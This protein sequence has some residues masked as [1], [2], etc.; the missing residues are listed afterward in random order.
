MYKSMN[1]KGSSET[2][3][4]ALRAVS[5][6]TNWS[7]IHDSVRNQECLGDEE[8]PGRNPKPSPM[9]HGYHGCQ[10]QTPTCCSAWQSPSCGGPTKPQPPASTEE[11]QPTTSK[12]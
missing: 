5:V 11:T 9:S 1:I 3:L 10:F 6:A 8:C 12:D 2:G 4:W 7:L